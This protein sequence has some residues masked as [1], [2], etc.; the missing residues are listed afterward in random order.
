[1]REAA[2]SSAGPAR[3]VLEEVP[4]GAPPPAPAGAPQPAPEGAPPQAG[5][6]E[7]EGPPAVLGRDSPVA[8]L[9][10]RLKVLRREGILDAAIY[11]TKQQLWERLVRCEAQFEEKNRL[12]AALADRQDRIVKGLDPEL[13]KSLKIPEKPDEATVQLHELTQR[14][15]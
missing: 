4:A 12:K 3:L 10:A 14:K 15:V 6:G 8:A 7:A 11:G 9:R 2:S 13:P 1:M 5:G